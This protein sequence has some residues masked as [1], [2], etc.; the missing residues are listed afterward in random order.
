[1]AQHS[2]PVKTAGA[3][4]RRVRVESV[5]FDQQIVVVSMPTVNTQ[6]KVPLSVRRSRL[7]LPVVGETWLIERT[8]GSQWTLAAPV[9]P[10]SPRPAVTGSRALSDPVSL[11]LLA[12]LVDLGLVDDQTTA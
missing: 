2:S 11:S 5:D 9:Y 10:A 1:M 7:D 12:A 4:V 3:M 8:L 6:I